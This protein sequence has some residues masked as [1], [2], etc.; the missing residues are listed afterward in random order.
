[1]CQRND[2]THIVFIKYHVV[3]INS[4]QGTWVDCFPE[5]Y[6]CR[7]VFNPYMQTYKVQ[8]MQEHSKL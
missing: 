2:A 3:F 4:P 8:T 6:V 5:F 7:N 1:M